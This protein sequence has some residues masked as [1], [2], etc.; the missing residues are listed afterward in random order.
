[1]DDKQH[2]RE[3]ERKMKAVESVVTMFE[4][5]LAALC[6]NAAGEAGKRWDK[7]GDKDGSK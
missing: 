4:M 1:V 2:E 3:H 5:A 7:L 6:E